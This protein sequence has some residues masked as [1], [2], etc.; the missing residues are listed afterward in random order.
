MRVLRLVRF[1]DA[2]CVEADLY[3]RCVSWGSRH[4]RG[5]AWEAC[6]ITEALTEDHAAL[7]A[8]LFRKRSSALCEMTRAL[9]ADKKKKGK[10]TRRP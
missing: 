3:E 1:K 2:G 4:R 8:K 10:R 7:S 5:A 6:C 9:P